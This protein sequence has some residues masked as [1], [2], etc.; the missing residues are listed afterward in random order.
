MYVHRRRTRIEIWT[1]AKLNLYLEVL[2]RRADGY[3]EID[4]LMVPIDLFDTLRLSPR[5]DDRIVLNTAWAKRSRSDTP[6][7]SL[8]PPTLN[9][10][11]RAVEL[12]RQR[13][14]VQCGLSMQLTKR[15]PV[16]A[17]LGG[18]SSDAAAALCGASRVWGLDWS[19][20]RLAELAVELGSDV[21]FFVYGTAARCRGR[22]ERVEPCAMRFRPHFV[23][24]RPPAGLAT[25]D[26]YARTELTQPRRTFSGS[27]WT[28]RPRHLV[29]VMFNR[30]QQAAEQLAPWIRQLQQQFCEIDLLG[31]QMSGSGSAYYGVCRS[32]KHARRIAALL[33]SRD[34]GEVF[35]ATSVIVGQHRVLPVGQI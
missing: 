29:H 8:P 35:A 28:Q 25:A 26:V 9:L 15:I 1:P 27:L 3:H 21:P 34:L 20:R 18:G 6:I 17:G 4:T 33:R 13:A 7:D 31:H 2:G 14:G 22:G 10:A 11:Y 23:V 24:V 30:L 32:A 19:R 5:A 16:E 12:L